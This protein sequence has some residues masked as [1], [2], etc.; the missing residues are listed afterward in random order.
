MIKKAI[1]ARHYGFCMGVKRA[2]NIA[3]ETARDSDEQV[4]I[5][6]EIVHNDA[7]VKDFR[8]KGVGQKFAVDDV[9][10]GTLIISAHGVSPDVIERATNKGLKVVDATCPLVT[11]IYDIIAKAVGQ[12]YYIIHLGDRNHDETTGVHGHAPDRITVISNKEELDQYPDWTDR[13]LGLTVQTTMGLEDFVEFQEAAQKKWPHIEVFETICNATNKRQTSIMDLAPEVD[14]ILVVGSTTSAN[15][16]RLANI[17]RLLCGRAELINSAFDIKA[18]WFEGDGDAVETVGV[19]AGA[20]TPDFLVQDVIRR[21]VKIS[22][23]T[24]E[25]VRQEKKKKARTAKIAG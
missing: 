19:S 3:E 21:L 4:T 22:G 10:T 7:V 9:E 17:A 14:M 5:L 8:E 11:R 15:S 1:I 20:S 2:I 16:G 25:V 18:E 6:N 12:D 24:A 23:G 13:K